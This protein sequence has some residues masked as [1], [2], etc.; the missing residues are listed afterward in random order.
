MQPN[1]D[2]VLQNRESIIAP[3]VAV[4]PPAIAT[5]VAP[6]YLQDGNDLHLRYVVLDPPVEIAQQQYEQAEGPAQEMEG[7][8]A[9][10]LPLHQPVPL[11]VYEA[12]ITRIHELQMVCRL[13]AHH[14]FHLLIVCYFV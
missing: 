10:M 14:P 2:I 3:G 4:Q 9:A 11:P 1:I 8:A 12:V 5:L 7:H 13:F 6:I